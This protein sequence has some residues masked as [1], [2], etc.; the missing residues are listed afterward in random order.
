MTDK[1]LFK[2]YQFNQSSP[3]L[4]HQSGGSEKFQ[5]ANYILEEQLGSGGMGQVWR[6]IDMHL[7]RPVALKLLPN[8][9][10]LNSEARARFLREAKTASVLNHP[11]IVTIFDTGEYE[12]QLYIAMEL[13]DGVT[14]R[15][16]ATRKDCSLEKTLDIVKQSLMGLSA[17]HQAGIVHR[18][19]KPE[20][21]MVRKDGY[22]K[23][24]DF[25]LAKIQ[26]SRDAQL[27]PASR[28]M[29]TP[30]YM[31]PEQVKNEP[32]DGRSDLFS[33]GAV[34][35]EMISGQPPFP[36][37]NL[38]QII[39]NIVSSEPAPLK[40]VP[41]ELNKIIMKALQ[42]DR[43]KRYESA[44]EFLADIAAFTGASLEIPSAVTE[45]SLVVL[46]LSCAREDEILADGIANEI[47]ANLTRIKKLRIIAS[48]TSKNYRDHNM[49]IQEIGQALNV[50]F[51]LE[52]SL[53]R[54][55]DRVRVQAQLVNARDGFQMWN[56]RFEVKARD[57]FDMEDEI[58]G[59][60]VSELNKHFVSMESMDIG[61][62][63][64]AIDS[65]AS[66]L[67][68]KGLSFQST[69]RID[70]AK[71]AIGLFM[72]VVE[73][74]PNFATAHAK[75]SISCSNLFRFMQPQAPPQ[76][77][78]QAEAEAQKAMSLE[79][80]NPDSHVAF[81]LAAKARGD[82]SSTIRYLREALR[83]APNH[84]TALSWLAYIYL[85]TGR[86]EEG[87]KLIRKAIERDP[88]GSTHYTFLGYA[89]IS[90]GRFMEAAN[91]LDRALR[92]DPRS[93]YSYA[94]M[95]MTNLFLGRMEEAR[96]THDFLLRSQNLPIQVQMMLA[97]Y[98]QVTASPPT[99]P[100]PP[101][102]LAKLAYEPEGERLAADIF[103]LRGDVATALRYLESSISKGLL[104]LAF[105]ER[106][107]FLRP[108]YADV[109]FLRLK[110]YLKNALTRFNTLS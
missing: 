63:T 10:L 74:A 81:A 78:A 93:Q 48:S 17:A 59:A 89:L 96:I 19:I 54:S 100:I 56:N 29:G 16:L 25:G 32:I 8:T 31:S 72:K 108:L 62:A 4:A 53:R 95:L 13:I 65:A 110:E 76:L 39:T 5:M 86:C 90:Q 43:L 73:L 103:A 92:I 42:K 109:G 40:G 83:L 3:K 98:D 45:T 84:V 12:Q 79:P 97:L 102:L 22:V 37:E 30:M 11:N 47:I 105:I 99:A 27:T 38:P 36:G 75:L 52:G 49:S 60:I 2:N 24:L 69:L 64:P 20:N 67:Y 1:R 34:L 50:H 33:M 82:F 80:A 51:A 77:L 23:V 107:P 7:A 46:P 18:D 66:E 94:L 101:D 21:L 58:S 28:I 104:N 9:L 106:D 41:A 6:A 71:Q 87:D 26:S 70:D 88:A 57:I 91:A 55:G 15:D 14:V 85:Y 68:F 44:S 35:Y 61:F